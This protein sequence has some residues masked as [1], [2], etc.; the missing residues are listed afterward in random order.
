MAAEAAARE[1]ARQEE[2]AAAAEAERER[3]RRRQAS[4]EEVVG[5]RRQLQEAQRKG[6]HV[7]AELVKASKMASSGNQVLRQ[8][9]QPKVNS[10]TQEKATI[11]EEIRALQ[12]KVA[13]YEG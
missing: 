12:D 7:E 2:E 9:M 4:A 11:Q 5:L 10:L 8:R 13:S 1:R 6:E 3:E